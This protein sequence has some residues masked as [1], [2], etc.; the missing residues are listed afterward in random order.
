LAAYITS[1][2]PSDVTPDWV[3]LYIGSIVV[4][5]MNSDIF[6]SLNSLYK[7]IYSSTSSEELANFIPSDRTID[8][9]RRILQGGVVTPENVLYFGEEKQGNGVYDYYYD[10]VTDTITWFCYVG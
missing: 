10:L 5:K 9:A 3:Q 2:L 4:N 7:V 8:I 1:V 6:S